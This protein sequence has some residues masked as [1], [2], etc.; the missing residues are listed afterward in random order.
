VLSATLAGLS[1]STTHCLIGAIAGVALVDGL[2]R[3]NMTTLKKILVS[4]VVTMPASAFFSLVVFC[5]MEAFAPIDG[6]V[7]TLTAAPT[8]I[9]QLP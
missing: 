9:P 1:V 6:S 5:V 4:W 2:D 8:P 7:V 3:L